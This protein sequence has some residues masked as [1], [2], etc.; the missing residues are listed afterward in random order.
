M[1]HDP[2]LQVAKI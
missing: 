2:L 1:Y